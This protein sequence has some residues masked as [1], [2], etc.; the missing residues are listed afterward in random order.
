[1]NIFNWCIKK[2]VEQQWK[3][4]KLLQKSF[5]VWLRWKSLLLIF[6]NSAKIC[7]KFVWILMATQSFSSHIVWKWLTCSSHTCCTSK[8]V[9]IHSSFILVCWLWSLYLISSIALCPS[10]MKWKNRNR[11]IRQPH[12]FF[13]QNHCPLL[14]II[15]RPCCQQFSQV[16]CLQL[17]V[18]A[19]KTVRS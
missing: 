14:W 16:L 17:K 12:L 6:T 11:T 1:M 15:H 13:L 18:V 2:T 4:C 7:I 3:C 5:Y 8:G 10:K 9:L 19:I